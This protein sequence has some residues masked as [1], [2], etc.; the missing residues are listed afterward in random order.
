MVSRIFQELMVHLATHGLMSKDSEHGR[1]KDH[2]QVAPED[3]NEEDS[4]HWTPIHSKCY[5]ESFIISIDHWEDYFHARC[6]IYA[7]QSRAQDFNFR[8]KVYK[9]NAK[10]NYFEYS[11]Q[12]IPVDIPREEH[13]DVFSFSNAMA[14]K[15]WDEREIKFKVSIEKK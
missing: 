12:P 4:L 1:F 3:F 15:V 6:Y 11:G 2:I 10:N 8:F 5:G 13:E 7:T 9:E 14:F